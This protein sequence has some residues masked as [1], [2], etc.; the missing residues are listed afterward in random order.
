[1]TT[2]ACDDCAL[3][4]SHGAGQEL[5]IEVPGR[6]GIEL[7]NALDQ[8]C[9]E[10][11]ALRFIVQRDEADLHDAY[12]RSIWRAAAERGRMTDS[13]GLDR[14]RMARPY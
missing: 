13:S 4:V 1:M 5:S 11:L 3:L 6:A 9:F 12:R 14:N 10:L 8:E 7:V 2:K